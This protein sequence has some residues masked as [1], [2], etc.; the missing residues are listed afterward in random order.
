MVA[1]III[2]LQLLVGSS[3]TDTTTT[4]GSVYQAPTSEIIVVTDQS[5]V[6]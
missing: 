5:I 1:A 4:D 2:A 3:S 6:N